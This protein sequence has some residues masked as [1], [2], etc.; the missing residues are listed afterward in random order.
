MVFLR[1]KNDIQLCFITLK[2]VEYKTHREKYTN[3]KYTVRYS[4]GKFIREIR[5]VYRNVA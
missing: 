4:Q 3:H 1:K 5:I 2:N